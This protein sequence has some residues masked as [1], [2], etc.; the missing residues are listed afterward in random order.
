MAVPRLHKFPL[1]P[2]FA[3]SVLAPKVRRQLCVNSAVVQACD[4]DVL[5]QNDQR[6]ELSARCRLSV[7]FLHRCT[8]LCSTP[9]CAEKV[10]QRSTEVGE[11]TQARP[12]RTS[13]RVGG[14]SRADPRSPQASTPRHAQGSND[15]ERVS[16]HL[17]RQSV[18]SESQRVKGVRTV[19][20]NEL[21][22]TALTSTRQGRD[23]HSPPLWR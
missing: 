6:H 20:R 4:F 18:A 7:N 1:I 15:L 19:C 3:L 8:N 22:A 16:L 13:S 9:E 14:P 12:V 17:L 11:K 5:R 2:R 23:K 21:N 10:Q